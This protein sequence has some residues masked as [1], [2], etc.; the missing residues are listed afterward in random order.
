MAPYVAPHAGNAVE[1]FSTTAVNEVKTISFHD[2]SVIPFLPV[3]HLSVGMP[4]K[5]FVAI[6]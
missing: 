6:F 3:T 1:V 5:L 2:H 4:H